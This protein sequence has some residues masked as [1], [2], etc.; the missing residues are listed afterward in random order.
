MGEVLGNSDHKIIRCDINCEVDVKENA[1]LVPNYKKGN[2]PGLKS[3]L[4]KINWQTAFANDDT[5][6]M[7]STLTNILLETESKWIPQVKKRL[8]STENPRW[9]T[10]NIK[11]ILTRKKNL[12]AKYKQAKSNDDYME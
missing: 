6:H 11:Q 9:M 5:E 10:K 1:F 7:C 12:Y 3:E 4:Q 2:I 8:N